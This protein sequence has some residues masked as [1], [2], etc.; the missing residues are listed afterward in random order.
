MDFELSEWRNPVGSE[1]SSEGYRSMSAQFEEFLGRSSKFGGLELTDS[2]GDERVVSLPGSDSDG[3]STRRKV[4]LLEDFPNTFLS[5]SSVLKAF[6]S[7]IVQF[8]ATNTPSMGA[9]F[10]KEEAFFE[11]ITP[12]VMIITETR[13][14][15]TTAAS[16]SFTAHRLLGADILGHP[17]VSTIEFNPIAPTLLTKALD[18]I[19][20]KEARHSGRRRKL[21]PSLLKRLGE[22]GDVR[23]AI[24]S[25]EFLCIRGE[26]GD[27]WD[28]RVA[29]RT[30]R[31]ANALSA[32]TKIEKQALEIDT[33]RESSLGLFHAVGRVVYNKRGDF[34]RNDPYEE[35]LVQPPNHMPEHARLRIPQV[36]VDQLIN[37]TGTD[38][39]TFVAALHENYVMSCEG[40]NFIES[41]NGCLG[42]LSDSD[43]LLSPQGR[44]FG[45]FGGRSFQGAASDSLRQDEI[46]F[47]L[48]VRGLLFA[49]PDPVKRRAHPFP[50]NSRGKN[51]TYKMFYPTSARL[52]R[53]TEDIESIVDTWSKR[54]RAGIFSNNHY[55]F[56]S[57]AVEATSTNTEPVRSFLDC[58]K[59]ELI[60]ERLPYIT[61]LEQRNPSTDISQLESIT[62]FH[63]ISARDNDDSDAE[64]IDDAISTM[65]WA[66]DRPADGRP[67]SSVVMKGVGQSVKEPETL[68]MPIEEEAGRLWLSDDD[69]VDD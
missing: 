11:N 49:L 47:Q 29:S 8:L 68:I 9:M 13:L 4:I 23:S 54:F 28:G 55:H 2:A 20:Q 22:V 43:L 30:K 59:S 46:A 53:H 32:V 19:C 38:T 26:D 48:A 40:T 65:K 57:T 3:K 63:G 44:G 37:E 6:R 36:S 50:G 45:D 64:D 7:S 33:Q 51:D 10:S 16:D 39:N 67:E 42:A 12:V 66:T 60:L 69:I 61:K 1:I 62:Q 27:D 31:G 17:G 5:T 18:L 52:S 14:D 34:I 25:L 58:T 15:S 35:P 24:G 21:G 41:L 56:Q